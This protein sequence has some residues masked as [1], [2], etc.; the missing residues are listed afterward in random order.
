MLT[1][2][3]LDHSL[4]ASTVGGLGDE[5]LLEA[6]RLALSNPS[7][8]QV[9]TVGREVAAPAIRRALLDLAYFIKLSSSGELPG[10]LEGELVEVPYRDWMS[11]VHALL[12]I[13]CA[14]ERGIGI[15]ELLRTNTH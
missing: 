11:V 3:D 14:N 4:V 13:C 2:D 8:E 1:L 10:D 6:V 7:V 12:V 5:K 15:T 9:Q